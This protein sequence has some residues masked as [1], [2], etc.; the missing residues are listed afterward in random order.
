MIQTSERKL[1]GAA[2]HNAAVIFVAGSEK[3]ERKE[4]DSAAELLAKYL[5]KQFKINFFMTLFYY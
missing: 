4:T 2:V 1:L 5:L 3:A